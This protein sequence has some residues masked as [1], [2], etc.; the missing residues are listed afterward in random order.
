MQAMVNK[1]CPA[2]KRGEVNGVSQSLASFFRAVGPF[3]GGLLWG[4]FSGLSVPGAQLIPFIV[5]SIITLGTAIIYH[6]L[7][8]V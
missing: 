3:L 6:F 8:S 7:P 5:I 4:V 2:A 1:F